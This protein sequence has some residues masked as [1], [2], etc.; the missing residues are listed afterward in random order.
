MP[1]PLQHHT[2]KDMLSRVRDRRPS[3]NNSAWI[4]SSVAVSWAKLLYYRAFAFVYGVAGG[5]FASRVMVNSSWTRGHIAALWRRSRP[6]T[7][8]FPPC[9]TS[10]LEVRRRR[11]AG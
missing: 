7:V 10:E 3:H 5:F 2:P 11:G 4:A 6:P 8:V 9:D 1:A